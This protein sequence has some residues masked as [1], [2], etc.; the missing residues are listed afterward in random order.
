MDIS[1][2]ASIDTEETP[3]SRARKKLSKE[4]SERKALVKVE[5]EWHE[6]AGAKV[7]K[8]TKMTNGNI[9]TTFVCHNIPKNKDIIS[10]LKKLK[11]ENKEL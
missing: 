11:P 1:D 10:A 4:K 8:K 6:V 5:R 2:K 3:Q 7:L 9:H